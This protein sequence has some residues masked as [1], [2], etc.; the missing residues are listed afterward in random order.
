MNILEKM[1]L[2]SEFIPSTISDYI[3]LALAKYLSET[4]DIQWYV[5][6]L[7]RFGP[8]HVFRQFGKSMRADPE[9]AQRR[10]RAILDH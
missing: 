6:C 2:Q 7:E 4:N 5:A 9:H 3:A 10:L 8:E 1:T